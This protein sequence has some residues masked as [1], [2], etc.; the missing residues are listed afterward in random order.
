M[1]LIAFIENKRINPAIPIS[2][3]N[4][5]LIAKPAWAA[6]SP[7]STGDYQV[8]FCNNLPSE[9]GRTTA[10]GVSALCGGCPFQKNLLFRGIRLIMMS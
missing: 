7:K 9:P 6:I 3:K 2:A 8:N 1:G 4:K 5:E 10:K